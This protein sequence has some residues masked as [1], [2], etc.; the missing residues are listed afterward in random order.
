M[1]PSKIL[2]VIRSLLAILQLRIRQKLQRS[3]S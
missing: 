1:N 2:Y 3:V